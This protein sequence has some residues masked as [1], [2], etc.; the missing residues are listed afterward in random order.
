[1]PKP[2]DWTRAEVEAAV[3]SYFSML[4]KALR[5]EPFVKAAY[6]RELRLR[7]NNRSKGSVEWKF[8]NISTVLRRLRVAYLPGYKP[9]SNIQGLLTE[10]VAAEL[11]KRPELHDLM[12]RDAFTTPDSPGFAGVL[13]SE[14]SPPEPEEDYSESHLPE[15]VIRPPIDYFALEAANRR[16]GYEGEKFVV[17]FERARLEAAGQPR[18]ASRVVHAS[19]V[20]GDGLGYDILSFNTDGGKRFIEVKTTK[21]DRFAPFYV[22]ANELKVSK[23][24]AE[25][26]HLYR[27]H[28]FGPK[29]RLFSRPGPLDASFALEPRTY[30]ARIG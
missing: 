7:L 5:R 23:L 19:V 25:R 10:V 14:E 8:G 6:I 26:Y 3:A 1:M 15:E 2:P 24:K 16:L 12:E 18:L 21:Y 4:E 11:F 27:V 22:S 17:E 20:R 13:T 30:V 29:P 28:S 9:A